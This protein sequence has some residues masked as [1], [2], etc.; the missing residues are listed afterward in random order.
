MSQT[1]I[2]SRYHPD[3]ELPPSVNDWI[4]VFGSNLAGRHG[5]G[6]AKVAK[7]TF[8]AEYG[9]GRGPTGRSYAIPTKDE[10][11]AVLHLPAI[12]QSI[13]DFILYAQTY[14]EK[15]FYVTRVGCGLAG[16]KN[17]QIGPLFASAP[18]NCS[19]PIQWKSYTTKTGAPL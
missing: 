19:L 13:N 14:P 8:G 5:A 15:L 4:W 6:S 10:R 11:L 7:V 16:Y 3:N 9:V 1:Q 18:P 2:F 17:E 12:E